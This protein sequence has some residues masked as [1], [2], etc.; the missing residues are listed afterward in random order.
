[1]RDDRDAVEGHPL[2]RDDGALLALP[3]R[4]AVIPPNQ[5]LCERFDPLGLI[6]ATTRAQSLVVSTSSPP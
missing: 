2:V 3:V 1:L 5:V 4:F 6:L